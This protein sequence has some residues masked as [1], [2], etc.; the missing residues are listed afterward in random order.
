MRHTRFLVVVALLMLLS[1]N[2]R[3]QTLSNVV[4]TLQ[5]D[6]VIITYDLEGTIAKQRFEVTIFYS[7]DDYASPLRLVDGDAGP[8]I[9]AGFGKR[10]VWRAK[11]ELQFYTGELTFEVRSLLTYSPLVMNEPGS[12]SS[13][14]LGKSL[15]IKWTGGTA[16]ENLQLEL[17]KASQMVTSI[18]SSGNTGNYI[19]AI[20]K[21]IKKGDD[22]QI[23]ILNPTRPND[24]VLSAN[25][26][27]K[28]GPNIVLIALPVAAG[29]GAAAYFLLKGDPDPGG[30]DCTNICTPGC[31]GYNPSDPSCNPVVVPVVLRKSVV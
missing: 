13:F 17:Y 16:N 6:Q 1:I 29:L 8:D 14:K 21:S 25:F 23:R 4:A 26:K 19:W 18:A 11:E 27:L 12:T 5:D 31:I 2:V 9:E 30:N 3:S 22:Y 24:A 28:S 10:V 20:P 7:H 15:P